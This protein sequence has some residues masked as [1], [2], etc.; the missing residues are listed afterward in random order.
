MSELKIEYVSIDDLKPHLFNAK[1]HTEEQVEQIKKS[2]K[3][4]GFNDPIAVCNN[5]I[6][7]GN[8]RY[9][10]AKQL[11]INTVP[12]VRL[13]NLNDEQRIAYGLVHNK[14]TMNTG[15]EDS[16]LKIEFESIEN[17]NMSDFDFDLNFCDEFEEDESE[18]IREKFD[19]EELRPFDKV[20][21]LITAPIGMNDLIIDSIFALKDLEGV[22]VKT[23]AN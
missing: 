2:I 21:Y 5:E 19:K 18:A 20:H 4:F 23:T 16:L 9:Y 10:A 13:D 12:I 3:E 11:G 8:G 1:I 17:I 22:D 6:V 14:L 15:F 7:E